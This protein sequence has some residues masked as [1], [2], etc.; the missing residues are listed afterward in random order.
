MR[1]VG[2]AREQVSGWRRVLVPQGLGGAALQRC[3]NCI[4]LT[5]ALATEVPLSALKLVLP[6]SL[7]PSGHTGLTSAAKAA[8]IR[9]GDDRSAK[10]LRH[11]KP[12]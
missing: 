2:Q 7:K 6:Q 12:K 8:G 1:R 5:V 11:P 9:A 10:A 4:A 3:G